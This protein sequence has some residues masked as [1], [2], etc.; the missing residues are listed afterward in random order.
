MYNSTTK[1]GTRS[2]LRSAGALTAVGEEKKN[3]V[4]PNNIYMFHFSL[5]LIKRSIEEAFIVPSSLDSRDLAKCHGI[6]F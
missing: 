6:K 5:F 4:Y 3:E 2:P 1:R